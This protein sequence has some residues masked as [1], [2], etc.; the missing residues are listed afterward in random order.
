MLVLKF[1]GTSVGSP[2]IIKK[3]IKIIQKTEKKEGRIA[4]VVSAFSKVTDKLIEVGTLAAK[5]DKNYKKIFEEIK[6]R[7]LSAVKKL[8]AKNKLEKILKNMQSVMKELEDLLHGIFLIKEISKRTLD[9]I[10]SFGERLSA[11]IISEAMDAEFLDARKIIK[12]AAAFGS[13][14]V[15][16]PKT[17]KNIQ[18][19]FKNHKKLQIITGFIGSTDNNET[20]TLGRGGSDYSAA[21]FGA[22]LNVREIEIWTDVDGIMT[23]DPRKVKK[24]FPIDNISYVEAME[25]SHFG[26]KVIHPPTMQPALDKNIPIRIKNTINPE[27]PGSVIGKKSD[28]KFPIKGISSISD[29]AL[30]LVQGSGMVGVPGVSKRLFGVRHTPDPGR[31][32]SA[33]GGSLRVQHFDK[34][35]TCADKT[36]QDSIS[37]RWILRYWDIE[38]LGRPKISQYLNIAISQL[39]PQL[40]LDYRTNILSIAAQFPIQLY[41]E[42]IAPV[43]YHS[44]PYWRKNNYARCGNLCPDS[45]RQRCVDSLPEYCE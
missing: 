23:A 19:Y 22:A 15:N 10:M 37:A 3:V 11:Y 27:F 2:E 32:Q 21:I 43:E 8:I 17:N 39:H 44:Q 20:S 6:E 45:G 34:G 13:A 1:G 29:I 14:K 33:G 40:F 18:E 24:A 26:A 12:T 28:S 5:G 9:L 16:F 36:G 4:I 30:L 38:I 35:T 7:H 42:T 31:D 25:M 41:L